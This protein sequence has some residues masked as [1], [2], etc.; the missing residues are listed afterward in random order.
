MEHLSLKSWVSSIVTTAKEVIKI[1]VC[2]VVQ[3]H[4]QLCMKQKEI[5][6]ETSAMIQ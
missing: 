1:I 4:N 6:Q 2:F 5:Q 3:R